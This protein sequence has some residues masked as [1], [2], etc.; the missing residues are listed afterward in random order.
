MNVLEMPIGI[1]IEG[2]LLLGGFL[3]IELYWIWRYWDNIKN[4]CPEASIFKHARE[5]GI[6]IM[7]KWYMSGF[8]VFE[9]LEKDKKG[10]MYAKIPPDSHEGI[11]FDPRIQSKTSKSYTKGGLEI[12]QY[13]SN[14]P[15][16]LSPLNAISM[17]QI[18]KY[19]RST[20]PELDFLTPQTVLEFCQK[21]KQVLIQDCINLVSTYNTIDSISIS[22]EK[23]VAIKEKIKEDMLDKYGVDTDAAKINFETE[24][25]YMNQIQKLKA[26]HL[27]MLFQKIQLELIHLTVEPGYFS[28]STAFQEM[29]SCITATDIQTYKQMIDRLAELKREVFDVRFF[30]AAGFFLLM[31]AIGAGIFYTMTSGA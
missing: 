11:R 6:A 24:K 7:Q 21:P 20:Y 8:F 12:Y 16:N 30:I 26:E 15:F 10:D 31:L 9:R 3:F 4:Y 27:A 17:N 29:I 22:H 19:V 2:V 23:S 25:E 28:F 18:V 14:S 1:P 5:N 13:G